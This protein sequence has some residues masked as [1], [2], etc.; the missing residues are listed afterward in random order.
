MLHTQRN[1]RSKQMD[2]GTAVLIITYLF[3]LLIINSIAP[4]S[5][6]EAQSQAKPGQ[7]P[8]NWST[9]TQR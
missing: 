4:I 2:K 9:K 3:L 7:Y 8:E 1:N 5:M 6:H